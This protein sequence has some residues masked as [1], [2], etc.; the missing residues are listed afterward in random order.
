VQRRS[1]F[2]LLPVVLQSECCYHPVSSFPRQRESSTCL[3]PLSRGQALAAGFRHPSRN[4]GGRRSFS[5]QD[6]PFAKGTT[7]SRPIPVQ[8][9][10]KIPAGTSPTGIFG[11]LSRPEGRHA[12]TFRA[13]FRRV[14][15]CSTVL[16]VVHPGWS[17]SAVVEG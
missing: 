1:R 8:G 2:E 9:N 17:R 10:K 3:P 14:Y 15:V 12:Q 4:D 6:Y 11:I 7:S 5:L 13:E 16:N